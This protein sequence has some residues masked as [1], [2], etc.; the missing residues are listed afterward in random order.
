ML[1]SGLFVL[2]FSI[3]LVVCAIRIGHTPAPP[4]DHFFEDETGDRENPFADLSAG[5]AE[6]GPCCRE[7]GD[8]V[9]F[10]AYRVCR[11]CL[12]RPLPGD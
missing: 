6:T 3:S 9:E 5:A 1:Y 8:A 12:T 2:L 10:P 4:R 7:C 11:S